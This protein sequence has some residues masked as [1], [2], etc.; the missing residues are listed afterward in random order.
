MLDQMDKSERKA[1]FEARDEFLTQDQLLGTSGQRIIILPHEA[2]QQDMVMSEANFGNGIKAEIM[3][4]D[5][6]VTAILKCNGQNIVAEDQPNELLG[7]HDFEHDGCHF[8][9]TVVDE[10]ELD[11]AAKAKYFKVA[12]A[13]FIQGCQQKIDDANLCFLAYAE[14]RNPNAKYI[15]IDKNEH[16]LRDGNWESGSGSVHSFVASAASSTKGL[17]EVKFGDVLKPATY[18]APAKHA[19]GN[20]FDANN[21]LG[22]VEWTGPGYLR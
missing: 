7:V 16:V 19:R 5:G 2:L 22:T 3:L 21:G 1:A 11:D 13:T 4:C 20:V 8:I 17:G 6:V 15:A 12:L 9:V 18:K 14:V 10:S